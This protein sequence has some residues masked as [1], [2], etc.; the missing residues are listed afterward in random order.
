MAD[1]E[2]FSLPADPP[3]APAQQQTLTGVF[4]RASYANSETGFTIASL[5]PEGSDIPVTIVGNLFGAREG[6]TLKLTGSWAQ[7]PKFGRQF[8]INSFVPILPTQTEAIQKYLASGLIRGIGEVYAQRIVNKFGLNTF[9][10]LDQTPERLHEVPGVG[11]KRREM[12]T[13]AWESQKSIREVILFLQEY[14]ISPAWAVRLYKIYGPHAAT[15]LRTD[16]FRL[17]LEV[18]GIGFAS[19]DKIARA[20]GIAAD[21]PKRIQAAV[22]HRLSEYANDGHTFAPYDL[23]EAETAKMIEVSPEPVREAVVELFRTGSL[24]CEKLP[25]GD[26]SVYDEPLHRAEVRVA[27]A[28]LRRLNVKKKWPQIDEDR[29]IEAFERRYNFQFASR[30]KQALQL[31]FKGQSLV[32]TGGPGTGKTTTVRGIIE[33]LSRHGVMIALAA[34]TGRAA[35]RLSETTRMPASTIHR[36]LKWNPQTGTFTYNENNPIEADVLIIDET[37]MLDITL[38]HS[39]MKAVPLRASLIFV[40]DI[41]QLPSV[42]PGN[43]LSDLIKSGIF[44][45]VRL[46]EIFR[47]AARSMIVVNAHRINQGQFPIVK[48]SE[49]FPNPDFF[50]IAKQEPAEVLDAVKEL[51]VDRIPKK[52]RLDP[53]NDVQV[54]T[55]M[56]R[57]DLGV[58]RLN[59]ALQQLLNPEKRVFMRGRLAFKIGDKVMQVRNNYEREVFNGDIGRIVSINEESQQ[60]GVV[61]DNRTVPYPYEDLDDLTLA[62]AITVH[63]SQGSEYPAVVIP[64][65]TQ[66][67]VLLQRNLFYTA[68]TRGKKLVCVVGSH[69][70]LNIAIKNA[71]EVVRFSGLRQRLMARDLT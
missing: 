49:E 1:N 27:E 6:E 4:D 12:I 10:V 67:Y 38:A 5:T 42:G 52:F 56:R 51:V 15:I 48:P 30:Q 70:A 23:L 64:L 33:I 69:R 11:R 21:D 31:A 8:K 7:H 71:G 68:I 26:K 13:R 62:Y 14:A 57:G 28:L 44:P 41:D 16:P 47:Q 46:D 20:A 9:E 53:L 50:F 35:K 24:I 60:V 66:H 55:P 43:F 25:E 61:F 3:A 45:V 63:K 17:A 37:S 40:G 54:I 2:L 18:S 29:E 58:T 32:L 39:L 36:L 59:E 19:A 34:P 65:H 22:K